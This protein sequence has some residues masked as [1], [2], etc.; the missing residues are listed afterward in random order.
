MQM[1][2]ATEACSR[3]T[4]DEKGFVIERRGGNRALGR[5]AK[6]RSVESYIGGVCLRASENGCC[7]ATYLQQRS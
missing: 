2:G 7:D 4:A 5:D 1:G 3:A 6:S